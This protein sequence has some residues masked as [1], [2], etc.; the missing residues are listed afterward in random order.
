MREEIRRYLAFAREKF[1]V[2]EFGAVRRCYPSYTLVQLQ[3]PCPQAQRA[4]L[5]IT[6]AGDRRRSSRFEQ[7]V[8]A[9]RTIV[10]SMLM[11]PMLVYA[12]VHSPS[13]RAFGHTVISTQTEQEVRSRYKALIDAENAHDI[14]AVRRFVWQSPSALFVAK[15]KTPEQGNWAGFWGDDAVVDHINELFQGTFVMAPDFGR[16]KVVQ[17]SREVVETYVP[18]TISVAYAGQSGTPKPFLMIVE[19]V[20]DGGEWKMA[21]D[22]ALPIPP[23]PR[24]SPAE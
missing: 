17:L 24:P 19:W 5:H 12:S 13:L 10:W 1:Q 14:D 22:I 21:T 15:T 9:L 2:P 11:S 6:S 7:G 16:E 23:A 4:V 3:C 18:L 20:K 8:L